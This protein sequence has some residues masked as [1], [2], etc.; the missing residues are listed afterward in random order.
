MI[1]HDNEYTLDFAHLLML[2]L[3][4]YFHVI[5]LSKKTMTDKKSKIF[6]QMKSPAIS[7]IFMNNF[8]RY[9]LIKLKNVR[10]HVYVCL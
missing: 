10:T 1:Y 7:I 9:G 8:N 6:T 3:E 5:Q 4:I 2:I